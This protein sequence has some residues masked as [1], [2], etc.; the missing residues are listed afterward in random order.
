MVFQKEDPTTENARFPKVA[1]LL[2]GGS[3]GKSAVDLSFRTGIIL[4]REAKFS[5][6]L[7]TS[8]VTLSMRRH[9]NQSEKV[10]QTFA[11]I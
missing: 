11:C 10:L 1:V 8:M 2:R 4:Y 3:R 5:L 7:I 9:R 6:P